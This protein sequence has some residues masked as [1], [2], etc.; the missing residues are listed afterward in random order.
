MATAAAAA[1]AFLLREVF[2]VQTLGQLLVRSAAHALYLTGEV[3][4]LAGHR[5]VEVHG[6]GGVGHLVDGALDYLTGLVQ[7]RDGAADDQ[8]VITHL[9]VNGEGR[10]G[11]VNEVFR[12]IDA[13]AVFG[14][15]DEVEAI[16]RLFALQGPFKLGKEH[17]GAVDVLQGVAGGGLIRDFTFYFECVAHGHDFVVLYFHLFS[18]LLFVVYPLKS[19]SAK[20]RVGTSLLWQGRASSPAASRRDHSVRKLPVISMPLTGRTILPSSKR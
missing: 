13:V 11:E 2:A 5:M 20:A 9:S 15:Q 1:T 12:V 6:H 10:L 14:A 4:G 8:Q 19:T 3:Q 17:A 16:A 7:H 18:L